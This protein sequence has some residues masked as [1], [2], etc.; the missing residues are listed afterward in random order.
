MKQIETTDRPWARAVSVALAFL[1]ALV[2]PTVVTLAVS[3]SL[4]RARHRRNLARITRG[5]CP[6]CGSA[7][8]GPRRL[9][10]MPTIFTRILD[11]ELPGEFVWR[12]DRCGVFLSIA[13]LRPGHALVVPVDEVDHWLD[14]APDG[15]A[16]LFTVAQVI[17]QAQMAAFSP[18][19]I[20]VIVAGLE[21]PH[22]HVHVIP[23]RDESDLIVADISEREGIELHTLHLPPLQRRCRHR[24]A[25]VCRPGLECG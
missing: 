8:D 10:P 14:L 22:T 13:P 16:H 11:G 6:R 9:R 20:G 17:G 2:L 24:L 19:R 18:T 3:R 1:P 15:V 25:G 23:I 4:K 12:D 21:V 5:L 7:A